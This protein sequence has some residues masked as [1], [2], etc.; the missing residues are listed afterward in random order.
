[1]LKAMQKI[2]LKISYAFCI[3][4]GTHGKERK[5]SLRSMFS[6]PLVVTYNNENILLENNKQNKQSAYASINLDKFSM[7]F[8]TGSL[9]ICMTQLSINSFNFLECMGCDVYLQNTCCIEI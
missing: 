3:C 8:G 1:M 6:L 5:G 4:H 9:E 2:Q 7:I